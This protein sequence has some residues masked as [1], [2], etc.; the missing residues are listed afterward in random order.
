MS[1][2][3]DP[4]ELKGKRALVTGGSR[5]IG[6]A[7]VQRLVAAGAQ[8]VTT[9]RNPVA[10]FPTNATF[11]KGDVGSVEGVQ[12]VAEQALAL[13]GGVDIL[14]NNAASGNVFTGG[15]LTIP[16]SE[17]LACLETCFLSAVRLTSALLPGMLERRS[18]SIV[19]ISSGAALTPP[20]PLLHYSAAK[21]ALISY[22]KGL[23]T[24]MAPRGVRVNTVTPGN[25]VTPGA[26]AV[27]EEFTKAYGVTAEIVTSAIPLRRMGVPEDIAEIVGFLVSDRAAWTTGSNFIVDGGEYPST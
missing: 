11:I 13:L 5:G 18:G 8:V 20:A 21:A 9:A 16:D 23:A 10:D 1:F 14:V 25:V 6:A 12:A 24:E 2:V 4:N 7:I 27:R 3:N 19:N 15:S 22:G 17:W 26:D